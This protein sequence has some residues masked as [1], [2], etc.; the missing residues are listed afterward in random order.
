MD[1][2]NTARRVEEIAEVLGITRLLGR[3]VAGLSGGEKQRTALAR[4]LVTDPRLLLLDEPVSAL[5]ESTRESVCAELRRLQRL[6]GVTTVHVS[7][8][9]EE[10]F[11]VADRGGVLSGGRFRQVGPMEELLRRPA[12]EFVARFM[13]CENIF[14]GEAVGPCAGATAVSVSG[15]EFLVPGKHQGTVHFVIR[16]E[17]VHPALRGDSDAEGNL[18]VLPVR[19]ERSVDRGAYV[20][21]HLTGAVQL[22]AHV[23]HRAFAGLAAAE[24]AEILALVPPEGIHVLPEDGTQPRT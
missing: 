5:D 8:N 24:G 22:A 9:L 2:T 19:L 21:V 3:R 13:R 11:S 20:R 15:A 14:A 6:L 23:P 16:P 12:T 1:R 4:A 18:T 7:H 10:A 17:N